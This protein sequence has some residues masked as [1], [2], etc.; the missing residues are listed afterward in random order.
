M[1][2]DPNLLA[3]GEAF[4]QLYAER[5]KEPTMTTCGRPA[6]VTQR[7]LLARLVMRSCRWSRPDRPLPQQVQAVGLAVMVDQRSRKRMKFPLLPARP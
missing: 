2:C 7:R 1:V 5:E 3:F 4:M 6:K